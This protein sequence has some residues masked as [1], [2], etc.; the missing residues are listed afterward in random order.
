ML[1]NTTHLKSLVIRATDGE[2][3]TVDQLYFDDESWAIRYLTVKTG[4]L[5]GGPGSPDLTILCDERGLASQ[6]VGCGADEKAS[7]GQPQHRY[8]AARFPTV[9]D[10]ISRLLRLSQLLERILPVGTRRL[11]RHDDSDRFS[12][13]SAGGKDP[14]SVDG[15]ASTQYCRRHRLS[16]RGYGW[17]NRPC[18]RIFHGR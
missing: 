8:A 12:E 15:L 6:A 11:S 18:G 7:Q 4:R 1:A 13:G 2:I 16:H 17:R 10:R 3:G 9:R 5:A 14:E